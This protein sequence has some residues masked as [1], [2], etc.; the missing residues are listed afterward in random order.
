MMTSHC[1]GAGRNR[2]MALVAVLWIVAALSILVTG[3]VKVQRDEIRLVSSARQTVQGHAMANAAIQMVLQEMA[4]RNEPVSRLSRVEV[5]YAG[6]AISVEI[7][8]LNGMIDINRASGPLLA[9]LFA[10]AGGLDADRASALAGRMT[11]CR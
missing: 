9:A 6:V 10:V 5:S 11:R 8:P 7:T 2:G 1:P 4:S 3:M